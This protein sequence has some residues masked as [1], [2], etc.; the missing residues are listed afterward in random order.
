MPSHP[1][2]ADLRATTGTAGTPV[3]RAYSAFCLSDN[4][5]TQ[6]S[7]QSSQPSSLD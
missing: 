6:S 4:E 1:E 5:M 3:S 2:L 7:Q